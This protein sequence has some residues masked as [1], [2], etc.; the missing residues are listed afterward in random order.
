MNIRILLPAVLLFAVCCL[1]AF[2]GPAAAQSYQGWRDMHCGPGTWPCAAPESGIVRNSVFTQDLADQ[3]AGG[4]YNCR[5]WIAEP[6]NDAT[7]RGDYPQPYGGGIARP[8]GTPSVIDG[9]IND[10]NLKRC[11]KL[12]ELNR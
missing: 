1:F 6:V 10:E 11:L 4:E 8:V 2:S 9:C 5:T 12:K 7:R 3:C